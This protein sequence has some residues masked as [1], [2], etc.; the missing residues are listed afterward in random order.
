MLVAGYCFA[1][2]LVVGALCATQAIFWRMNGRALW[3]GIVPYSV[4]QKMFPKDP[5]R[6]D[7]FMALEE[8]TAL[9]TAG[10]LLTLPLIAMHA[11]G[12]INI[13]PWSMR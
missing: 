5:V 9:L 8:W 10:A 11:A 7:A 6:M 3:R 1:F 12:F 13:F 2:L 4:R